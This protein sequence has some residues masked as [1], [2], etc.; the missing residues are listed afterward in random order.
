MGFSRAR[1]KVWV[2]N[3]YT[4]IGSLIDAILVVYDMLSKI[5]HFIAMTKST[6]VK[7]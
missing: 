6:S 1:D 7:G 4:K 5:T 3:L 2:L